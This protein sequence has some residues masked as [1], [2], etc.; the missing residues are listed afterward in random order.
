V[1]VRRETLQIARLAPTLLTDSADLVAAFVRGRLN[2]DGG[3]ANRAGDSD[4]YYT[5]FGLQALLALRADL[6]VGPTTR[7]L[8]QFADGESLDLIH[9]A[10]LAG[11]WAMV[12][13]GQ[14][15]AGVGKKILERIE[16]YR[17]PD[18]G[19]HASRDAERG[20]AYHAFL[21]LGAY[22][23]LNAAPPD[24]G[25]L[26]ASIL[27]LQAA[28]G[29]FANDAGLPHGQTPATAASVALLRHLNVTPPPQIAE[30]LLLQRRDGGFLASPQTPVPD[31]LS[32]AVAL[33]ALTALHAPLDAIRES[34]LDFIDTLW[35]GQ[36]A[37]LG[38]WL[39]DAA[40]C[41]YTY[42]GLLALGH[43]AV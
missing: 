40:D 43:L 31:L 23:D 35:T 25:R 17:T 3:F 20:T 4:L 13:V 12:G 1:S 27:T 26:A 18:G 7:Y 16:K 41:E 5:V 10:C 22:E 21:A 2:Q 38:S 8:S 24:P 33:H 29:A 37:F 28:D 42:Y 39:D 19:Y 6:P 11:C 36:G 14:L 15:A 9:L 32:T 34:C 30:W